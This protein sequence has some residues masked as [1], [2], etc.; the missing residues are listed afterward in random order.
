MSSYTIAAGVMVDKIDAEGVLF[1]QGHAMGGH[2]LFIKD[3]KLHYVYNWLGEDVQQVASN[4][5]IRTGRH[6][7]TAEFSKTG[8]DPQTRSTLGTLTFYVDTEQVGQAEIKTQ[9]SFFSGVE[10]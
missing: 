5:E 1:A 10:A 6:L 9:P 3:T 2:S 4:V 7:F 8:Q